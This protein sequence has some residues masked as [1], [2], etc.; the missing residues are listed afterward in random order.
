MLTLFTAMIEAA[1]TFLSKIAGGFVTR[2]VTKLIDRFKRPKV[3]LRRAPENMFD[4]LCPGTSLERMREILGAPHRES[5]GQY[6]Y[7]FRDALVQIR[8]KDQKSITSVAVAIP[9]IDKKSQFA[10][11][12]TALVLGKV[13]LN[14]VLPDSESGLKKDSSTKHWGIWVRNYYGFPGLYRYYT[15]GV[16]EAPCLECPSFEWDH[17]TDTLKSKPEDVI[18]NWASVSSSSEEGEWFDFWAFV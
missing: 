9:R 11:P 10:I 5:D 3:T 13:R 8:S 2:W 4:Q 18:I 1:L 16:L 15:F 14:Q 12:P 7:S 6:S 17:A